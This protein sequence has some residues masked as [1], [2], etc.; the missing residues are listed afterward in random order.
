MATSDELRRVVLQ[1]LSGRGAHV[2][3]TEALDALAWRDAGRRGA[4]WPHSVFQIANHLVY[5]QDFSLAWIDGDE[6]ETPAHAAESWP[7]AQAPA[8]EAEWHRTLAAFRAGL[9]ALERR[10]RERDL[11][12]VVGAKSV[13]EILQLIASHNSYHLGQVTWARRELGAWPPPGGG[14]TW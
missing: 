7:G 13:L 1:A 11:H 9:E 14:A 5:W 2:L 10:A 4:A 8:S 3:A 12:E 6:P